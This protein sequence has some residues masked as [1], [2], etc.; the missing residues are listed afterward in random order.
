M[1]SLIT[2]DDYYVSQN[3]C[4]AARRHIP[5]A[6]EPHMAHNKTLAEPVERDVNATEAPW[7]QRLA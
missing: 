1:R 5:L 4:I 6:S 3:A 7:E 2:T